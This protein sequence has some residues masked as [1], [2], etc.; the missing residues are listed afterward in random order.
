M[1]SYSE[2]ASLRK[3]ILGSVED[4]KPSCWAWKADP[5]V[6]AENFS[7]ARG[8][9]DTAIPDKILAEVSEDL[10]DYARAL[11]ELGV[12][13]IRPPR[14]SGEPVLETEFFYSYGRDFYNMRDLHIVLGNKILSSSPSQPNRILEINELR[15]FLSKVSKESDLE[16]LISPEPYL[17]D[18]PV[19]PNIRNASGDLVSME[20]SLA[21]ILGSVTQEIWHRL[22]EN[23]I[24]FDAANIVRYD[25]NA[26][27]LVSSTGNSKAYDWLNS[28]DTG[29]HIQQTDVYRSS[30]IDST[31]LPLDQDTFLVNS[32]RVN[33]M[34]LPVSIKDKRILY[35][36]DVAIIPQSEI[37][38]HQKYRATA[39]EQIEKVGFQT[40]LQEMS[41]P[42]AGMNVLSIDE[43]TVMVESNQIQLIRYLES[44]GYSVIP[45]RMRHAYTMLG[46]LH[47]TTLDIKRA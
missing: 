3:V 38:F 2:Y 1:A 15:E 40:N 44:N 35:F 46:G 30:H 43:K 9:C 23:E 28:I 37:T 42:W 47:C 16:F 27:Y 4:Y 8:I 7:R 19:Y 31:I 45:I 25:G 39:A 21:P 24:L 6:T 10:T 14:I 11:K 13:V 32:V 18:N 36:K 34:N 20:E 22:S 26:L 33:P 17:R 29:F 41:S 5:G 12:E